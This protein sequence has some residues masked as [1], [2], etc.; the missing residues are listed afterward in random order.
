MTYRV[1]RQRWFRGQG[2]GESAL[3]RHQE[4]G[5]MCCMGFVCLAHGYEQEDI[6]HKDYT[7]DLDD[8]GLKLPEWMR[9][10]DGVSGVCDEFER[11]ICRVYQ[12]N[13][14]ERIGDESRE[15]ILK[16]VFAAHGDEIEF[17]N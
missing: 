15:H 6:L 5:K 14:D 7:A 4:D 12:A 9:G 8:D 10:G 2:A 11:S 3:M 13:D 16:E 1:D 17:F